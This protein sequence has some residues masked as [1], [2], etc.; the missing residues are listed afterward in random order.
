MSNNPEVRN[1]DYPT[2]AIFLQKQEE[3][4]NGWASRVFLGYFCAMRLKNM[5]P[6]KEHYFDFS[7]SSFFNC[8]HI[9]LVFLIGE[10][11]ETDF[12]S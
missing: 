11:K 12:L 4:I 1:Q 2:T 7:C 6:K 5:L 3:M 9:F 8:W 10:E